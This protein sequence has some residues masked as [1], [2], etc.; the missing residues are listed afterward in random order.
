MSGA[1]I[2]HPR[3]FSLEQGPLQETTHVQ[4][5]E[6]NGSWGAPTP[7]DTSTTQLLCSRNVTEEWVGGESWKLRRPAEI[8][9]SR[10]D[11]EATSMNPQQENINRYTNA[12]RR[13]L[14]RPY[15]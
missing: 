5:T 11:R 2:T 13:N 12:D 9:S 1:L 14:I 7:A 15:P 4:N 3:N 10:K 8:A 6:S